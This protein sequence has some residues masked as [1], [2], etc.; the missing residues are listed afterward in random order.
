MI[1]GANPETI[2]I[3][4]KAKD[5]GLSVIVV[6]PNQFSPAKRYADKSFEVDGLNEKELI[7]LGRALSIDAILV[8]VADVL[9]KSYVSVAN[10]LNLPTYG[11]KKFISIL[12]NKQLFSESL[13]KFG[14]SPIPSYEEQEI[15]NLKQTD[16]PLLIKPTDSGGGVG[17]TICKKLEDV[18]KAIIKAKNSSLS[19]K[20]IAE[21][22]MECD[23]M[24]VYITIVNGEAFLSTIADRFTSKLQGSLTP[25]CIGA[26]YPSVHAERFILSVFPRI[27]KML[28]AIGVVNGILNIQFFYDG[29]EFYAYDP[30]FRLQGEG[31]HYI[32]QD[33]NDIDHIEMLIN[34]ALNGVFDLD[35]F[36]SK[37]D[38]MLKN[39][40]AASIWILLK[41]GKISKIDGLNQVKS[42]SSVIKIIQRFEEGDN[43]TKDM[44]GNEKQ[45]FA[46]IYIKDKSFAGIKQT[47]KFIKDNLKIYDKSGVSLILDCLSEENF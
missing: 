40:K 31:S 21:K 25:V 2:P 3:V 33:I 28:K 32:M 16:F 10:N 19:K 37:N 23:D 38:F 12:T 5:M 4:K 18:D 8:G 13:N 15:Y 11:D 6:D 46:R 39:L 27:K 26:T 7:K 22:F 47:V 43:I 9:I 14:I 30:G 29:K 24:G 44:I 1:L 36:K 17:M 34:F 41:E 42:L 45:V 35:N 20:F